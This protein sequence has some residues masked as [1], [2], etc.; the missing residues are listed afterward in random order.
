MTSPWLEPEPAAAAL[1]FPRVTLPSEATVS[2]EAATRFL[3]EHLRAAGLL[4]REQVEE[5]VRA[6]LKREE[7]ASTG[8]GH[9]LAL[10][11]ARVFLPRSLGILGHVPQGM[12]WKSLDQ[13]PVRLICLL[14]QAGQGG[15]VLRFC[16]RA[17]GYFRQHGHPLGKSPSG[18]RKEPLTPRGILETVV[19][20]P[21]LDAAE[22]FYVQVLGLSV[23]SR[24]PGRHV[25]FRCGAGM[26]LVFNPQTTA[27][28]SVPVGD[29]LIPRHGAHGPGHMAFRVNEADLPA[30]RQRLREAGVAIESEIHWPGGG[31]SLYFRDPAGNSIEVATPALWGLSETP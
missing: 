9:G 14:L 6:L 1:G 18:E 20:V 16:E 10:P 19:Y 30:W 31:T 5:A 11:H 3:L 22:R 26:F 8:V 28:A 23:L 29:A 15:D 17:Y 25:F 2:V 12:D 13:Q 7:L 27:T 21:D 24:E 4:S